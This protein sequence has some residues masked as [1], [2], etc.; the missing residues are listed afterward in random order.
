MRLAVWLSLAAFGAGV[1]AILGGSL[2]G[3][4][5]KALRPAV[6]AHCSACYLIGEAAAQLRADLTPTGVPLH[7]SGELEIAV[8]EAAAAARAG[9]TVLL[10]PACASFDAFRDYE[11]RGDRFRDL[12]ADLEALT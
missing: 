2:K 9:E 4:D 8:A 5:F 6:A 1:H 10:A 11:Q 12:V 7:D 3:G